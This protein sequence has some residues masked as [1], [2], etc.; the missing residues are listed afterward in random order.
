MRSLSSGLTIKP[1]GLIVDNSTDSPLYASVRAMSTK[2][3][4]VTGLGVGWCR[5]ACEYVVN[6]YPETDM[7]S[8]YIGGCKIVDSMT[9]YDLGI[10]YNNPSGHDVIAPARS[11]AERE[12]TPVQVQATLLSQTVSG[13]EEDPQ[14]PLEK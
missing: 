3:A 9:D 6:P 4:C 7:K 2:K 11:L 1:L 10:Y 5:G 13:A 12:D 14:T 8:K